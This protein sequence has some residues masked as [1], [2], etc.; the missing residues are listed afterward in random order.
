LAKSYSRHATIV[1]DEDDN[2]TRRR[3]T[4]A[5]P[6]AT[7][8]VMPGRLDLKQLEPVDQKGEVDTCSRCSPIRS[9]ADGQARRG[10]LLLDHVAADGVHACIYLFT[11]DMEME[12]APGFKLTSWERGYARHEDGAGPRD[13]P[14]DPWLRRPRWSSAMSTPKRRTDRGSAAVDAQAADR[15]C[16]VDGLTSSRPRPSSSSTAS[17]IRSRGARQAYTRLDPVSGYLEDY[18]IL[19]T[20]KKSR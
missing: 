17:R 19:Q 2:G 9:A 14:V 10:Q 6:Y 18:H 12:A 20:S 7:I 8:R 13:D 16:G 1:R 3:M 11:V 5:G 15:A 4:Q